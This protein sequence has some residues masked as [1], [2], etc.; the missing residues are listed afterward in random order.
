MAVLEQGPRVGDPD[1]QP[2]E[3][4]P[5][6]GQVILLTAFEEDGSQFET[7][8]MRWDGAKENGLYP[9]KIGMWTTPGGSLTWQESPDGGPTHWRPV[10]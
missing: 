1:W 7:W 9:G 5:K 4:A 8:P 2:I 10:P 3:T 6:D